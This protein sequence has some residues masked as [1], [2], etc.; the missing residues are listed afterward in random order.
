MGTY[1]EEVGKKLNELLERTYDAEKGYKKAAENINHT[2]LKNYFNSK[3][4]QRYD[5]GHELKSEIKSFGQEVDK[6]GSIKGSLHRAWMDTKALFSSENE[7]SMLEESIRG[8]K[9]AVSDYNEVINETSLPASTKS[10]LQDQRS[11][12]EAGL[13]TIKG[14]EDIVD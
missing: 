1:T 10:I 5:F 2:G 3:A 6:G 14:L 7:E 9:T 11:K 12:I 13:N 4:Q 8:E